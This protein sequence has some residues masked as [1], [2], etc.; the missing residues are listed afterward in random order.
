MT[1]AVAEQNK[2]AEITETDEIR[3][4][5]KRNRELNET[6]YADKDIESLISTLSGLCALNVCEGNEAETYYGILDFR[7]FVRGKYAELSENK[8]NKYEKELEKVLEEAN[9]ELEF[10]KKNIISQTEI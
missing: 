1:V 9:E 8:A 4:F 2:I 6:I 10:L 3:E 7:D 5:R